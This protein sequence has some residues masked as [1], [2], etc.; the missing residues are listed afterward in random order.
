MHEFGI[1]NSILDAVR[2]EARLRPGIV[3]RTVGLRVGEAAGVDPDSLGFCFDALV[4]GT[5][6]DPLALKIEMA[7][8]RHECP[9]CEREFRVTDF[10]SSCPG[11]GEP[12]TVRKGGFEL[13]LAYME[14][15]EP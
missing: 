8:L 1:A 11:C 2:E 15:E 3:V 13:D 4:R 12:R 7:P 9:R 14:V 6:L 5:D 10:D